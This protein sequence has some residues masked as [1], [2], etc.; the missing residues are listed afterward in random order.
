MLIRVKQ[1]HIDKGKPNNCIRCPIAL[2]LYDQVPFKYGIYVMGFG[3]VIDSVTYK[4]PT[5]I[6]QFIE[7][8]DKLLDVNPFEFELC[9]SK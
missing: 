1:E 8:F 3:I 4:L 7:D 9:L 5:K 2:A 6:K